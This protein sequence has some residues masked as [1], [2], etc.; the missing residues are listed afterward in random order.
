MK[1]ARTMSPKGNG[2]AKKWKFLCH[3]AANRNHLH[4]NAAHAD[5][6]EGDRDGVE[7]DEKCIAG[8]DPGDD[9][10]HAVGRRF[11]IE[12]LVVVVRTTA[13][14]KISPATC[15]DDRPG[16]PA[17][18]RP[19]A[20]DPEKP[21]Y[22]G[23]AETNHPGQ[24]NVGKRMPDV[25]DEIEMAEESREFVALFDADLFNHVGVMCH[26]SGPDEKYAP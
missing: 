23:R 2:P 7:E 15:S 26:Q 8:P 14:K 3:L 11:R 24:E 18:E 21:Q 4:G 17:G 10:H 16:H 25:V 9:G 13:G 19:A 12:P 6:I 1:I 22:F 5:G 20:N